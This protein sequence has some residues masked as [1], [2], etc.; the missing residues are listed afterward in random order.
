MQ[1]RGQLVHHLN[2]RH[3]QGHR[4]PGEQAV[5]HT[6]IAAL[7]VQTVA[8]ILHQRGHYGQDLTH[9][10]HRHQRGQSE[11]HRHRQ[12]QLIQP[13]DAGVAQHRPQQALQRLHVHHLHESAQ[14]RAHPEQIAVIDQTQHH[15]FARRQGQQGG[16]LGGLAGAVIVGRC[17]ALQGVAAREHGIAEGAG[18]VQGQ[19]PDGR[20]RAAAAGG[21]H[22]D[23]GDAQQAV[24]QVALGVDVLDTAIV[25][26]AQI[27][28]NQAVTD[29]QAVVGEIVAV[30]PLVPERAQRPQ[31]Q[32]RHHHPEQ[33]AALGAQRHR[34][35]DRDHRAQAAHQLEHPAERVQAFF[36]KRLATLIPHRRRLRRPGA[37]GCRAMPARCRGRGRAARCR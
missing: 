27:A 32:Q 29:H 28:E 7:L 36:R 30:H 25:D 2:A 6:Q 8:V 1:R 24:Q 13:G 18:V 31:Q 14:H 33:A 26:L 11:Q 23:V 15:Q 5:A 20:F 17:R 12:P 21:L 3:P 37:A 9:R 19:H 34:H 10:Q 22:L 35:A 4:H 16:A